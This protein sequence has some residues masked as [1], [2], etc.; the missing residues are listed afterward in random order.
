MKLI[1]S[2]S[3]FSILISILLF[4]SCKKN[5]LISNEVVNDSIHG[6]DGYRNEEF[7]VTNGRLHFTSTESFD[8]TLQI[9]LNYS[10]SAMDV[11]EKEI[12]FNSFRNSSD[13]N[14]LHSSL[15]PLNNFLNKDQIIQIADTTYKVD[16]SGSIISVTYTYPSTELNVVSLIRGDEDSKNVFL[17]LKEDL[18]IDTTRGSGTIDRGGNCAGSAGR[19]KS[20]PKYTVGEDKFRFKVKAAYVNIIFY[21]TLYISI[22]S[23]KKV[24][25][26][27]HD[28]IAPYMDAFACYA[29]QPKNKNQQQGS[30]YNIIQYGKD[31]KVTLYSSTRCLS[32][33]YV[34]SYFKYKKVGS[35]G[36]FPYSDYDFVDLAYINDYYD[37]CTP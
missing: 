7:A 25:I 16:L 19:E 8:S 17:L 37:S 14:D 27:W 5:V 13:T 30:A 2:L 20:T 3:I 22:K 28:V 9:F 1:F 32:K 11:W 31:C 36:G 6:C 18:N 35:G 10:D 15:L 23:D 34:D 26:G 4:N 21:K 12:N 24:D 33:Y 29:F